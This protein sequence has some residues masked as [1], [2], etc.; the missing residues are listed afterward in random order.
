MSPEAQDEADEAMEYILSSDHCIWCFVLIIILKIQLKTNYQH[1]ILKRIVS[2]VHSNLYNK[3]TPLTKY[4]YTIE[5]TNNTYDTYVGMFP[6][7]VDTSLKFYNRKPSNHFI[8]KY[9]S[10]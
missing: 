6:N 1:D 5:K 10:S 3:K 9:L 8:G 7:H 2:T 4:I